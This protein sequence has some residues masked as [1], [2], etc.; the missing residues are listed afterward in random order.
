MAA[1][2][3]KAE[4][5]APQKSEV[6][7]FGEYSTIPGVITDTV[8]ALI[9]GD[10]PLVVHRF[11]SKAREMIL[12]KHIGKASA[13]REKKDPVVNFEN[14]AH[15]LT[16]GSYGYPAA[17][18]KAAVAGAADNKAGF[19][20]AAAKGALRVMADCDATQLIRIIGPA[21]EDMGPPRHDFEYEGPAWPRLREDM[22]RNATGV[23]DIR[24]RPEFFPW[25]MHLR[26]TYLPSLVSREQVLQTL[27][28]AGFKC[29]LGEWRPSSKLSMSGNLG[30]FRLAEGHEILAFQKG[31]LFSKVAAEAERRATFKQAAE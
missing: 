23:A 19:A 26:I 14:A 2:R 18:V 10:A 13:G 29:G 4:A 28:I 11:S 15:R 12:S 21:L 8:T 6:I 1:A 17:G 5:T 7:E 9:I 20:K 27:S 31:L 22:V 25:A 30:T 24:H 3:K 16:D